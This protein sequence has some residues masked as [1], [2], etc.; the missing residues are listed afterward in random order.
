MPAVETTVLRSL[1]PPEVAETVLT[2]K[3][4]RCQSSV[5]QKRRQIEL[6]L[7]LNANI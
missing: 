3:N 4:I 6:W 5:T 7:L 1:L 2:L